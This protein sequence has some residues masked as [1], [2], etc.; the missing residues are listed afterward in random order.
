MSNKREGKKD[1]LGRKIGKIFLVL[2]L[3]IVVAVGGMLG[4][5]SVTEYKPDDVEELAVSGSADNTVKEGDSLRIMT[6]NIGYGALGDNAD[7]FM[8]GGSMV[9][10]ADEQRV[11]ENM[12]AIRSEI[13]SID[14]DI[15][16]L[17]EVDVDSARS[18]H[19]NEV[20]YIQEIPGYESAFA[21]N[22]KTAFIPYPIPPMGKVDSGILTISKY[23]IASAER[24]SLPC[25]FSWPVSMANLKR[26]LN[27]AVV[28]VEGSEHSLYLVNLH[29]EAYDD[30]E[31]KIAQTKQLKELL[32]TAADNGDYVIAGG[33]F[34]QSFS[35][36]DI[37][38]YPV[39]EGMWQPGI[40][41]TLEFDES[42]QFV[43][44]NSTP[45]CRS[46]DRTLTE[47]ES[48]Y[49]TD[50]QYYMIDGFIVSDNISVESIETKDL[51]FVNSDHNPVVM[52]I[53]LKE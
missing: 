44:D 10:T 22:F 40:I 27:V 23:E 45:S 7:F 53:T 20:E 21:N 47:V 25:P 11:S 43:M 8:D 26:C 19:T 38:E 51:G 32:E 48:V 6:W 5:L 15:A 28:P 42:L 30:G 17:Q 50:F 13:S 3:I 46:L 29:L 39:L 1:G 37:S 9:Y 52:D 14:P 4:F 33:D 35:N 34:N 18:R 2:I 41:D 31:G 16:L 49:P 24:I 36:I 12:E